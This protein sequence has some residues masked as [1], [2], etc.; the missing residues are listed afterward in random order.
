MSSMSWMAEKSTLELVPMLK[1]AYTALKDKEQDLVLAAELGKSLLDYNIRLKSKYDSLLTQQQTAA[2]IFSP[3]STSA[4]T[5][6]INATSVGTFTPPIT[7][8]T[9]TQDNGSPT[10]EAN[11]SAGIIMD[12]MLDA[13]N[14]EDDDMKFI[15]SSSAREAMIEALQQ[16]NIELSQKLDI[17][18]QEK[19]SLSHTHSRRTKELEMDIQLL[20]SDLDIATTKIQELQEINERQKRHRML[21]EQKQKE[22]ETRQQMLLVDDLIVQ[23]DELRTEKEALLQSKIDL[24]SKLVATLRDLGDLKQQFQS[25]EFSQKNMEELQNAYQKQFEHIDEL[26]HSLE[27]HRALLQKLKEKGVQLYTPTPSER[28]SSGSDYG[29]GNEFTMDDYFAKSSLLDELGLEWRKNEEELATSFISTPRLSAS[30]TIDNQKSTTI[31]SYEHNIVDFESVLSK[32]TGIDQSLIDDALQFIDQIEKQHQKEKYLALLDQRIVDDNHK[33]VDDSDLPA[34]DL[35]PNAMLSSILQK[36]QQDQQSEESRNVSVLRRRQFELKRV[37]LGLFHMVWRW[38]RFAIVL[39]I[40]LFI[41][42]AK[43]PSSLSRDRK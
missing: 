4:T 1:N 36:H 15:P 16:K 40:A 21:E 11:K 32:A 25:F 37:I 38:S 34:F 19:D 24:E 26:N 6:S 17:A 7:P 18:M 42:A 35:Y 12:R 14:S 39:I 28:C 33:I 31:T 29:H 43:G 23:V 22:Q 2:A 20:K 9:S 10:T 13:T 3:A 5:T 41:S 27:E 8:S 30:M